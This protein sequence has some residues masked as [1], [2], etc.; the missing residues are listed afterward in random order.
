[1]TVTWRSSL[2][3]YIPNFECGFDIW[4]NKG[5][6]NGRRKKYTSWRK[7]SY[8]RWW[9]WGPCLCPCSAQVLIFTSQTLWIPF[10][11]YLLMLVN[12]KMMSNA[13]IWVLFY[14]RICICLLELMPQGLGLRSFQFSIHFGGVE[15]CRGN[16]IPLCPPLISWGWFIQKPYCFKVVT[17]NLKHRIWL[18]S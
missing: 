13:S 9:H 3:A 18:L 14:V 11:W 10:W 5:A 8:C 17:G 16:P 7:Y 15:C 1:M 2:R 12:I 6:S 4:M